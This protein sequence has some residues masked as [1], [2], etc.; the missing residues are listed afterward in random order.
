MPTFSDLIFG[1][2]DVQG[3]VL[4]NGF[5][6]PTGSVASARFVYRNMVDGTPWAAV[7]YYEG[8]VAYRDDQTWDGGATGTK[9]IRVQDPNGLLPGNYRLEL[10]L[11]TEGAMRLAATSDFTLAGAQQ[12]AFARIFSNLHFTTA[13]SDSEALDVAPISTF[14]ASTD[15]IYALFDWEQIASGT[16]WTMRWSVDDEVFYEQTQPWNAAESGQNFLVRLTSPGGIPDGTYKLDLLVGQIPFGSTTARVGI[17]QLPID[18]FSQASGTQMRGQVLDGE[19]RVGIPGVTVV[20][21]NENFSVSE[22]TDQWSQDQVYSMAITDSSGNF[23]I[24]RLLQSNVPYSVVIIAEGYLPIAADG[25]KV[26]PDQQSVD[27]PIYL[28]KG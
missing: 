16:L 8:E 28:T 27:V 21:I 7:W 1:L 15:T 2:E 26:K 19:T 18:R 11:Q 4:G 6:L 14:S 9:T 5:V 13:G 3:D 17:G 24:D 22:F 25:V 20:L 12:G 23:Q 10:Y